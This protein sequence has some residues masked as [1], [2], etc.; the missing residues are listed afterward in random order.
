MAVKV[1]EVCF[2]PEAMQITVFFCFVS[3][4][5]ENTVKSMRYR[6]HA[7]NSPNVLNVLR[8]LQD[9]SEVSSEVKSSCGQRPKGYK[10]RSLLSA[11]ESS[12]QWGLLGVN[13][14]QD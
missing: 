2:S 13:Q 3:F 6:S 9:G 4:Q 12:E 10:T 8:F 11:L 1:D 5:F 7:A 14:S